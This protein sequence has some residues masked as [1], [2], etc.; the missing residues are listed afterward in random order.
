MG[1]GLPHLLRATTGLLLATHN[2]YVRWAEMLRARLV[3]QRARLPQA[4]PFLDYLHFP[5][6]L[7]HTWLPSTQNQCGTYESLMF[8]VVIPTCIPRR[9][10]SSRRH[11]TTW[12]PPLSASPSSSNRYSLTFLAT[13]SLAFSA[14]R[15]S[16]VRLSHGR[17][18]CNSLISTRPPQH[19]R[20][21]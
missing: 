20:Y 18:S 6:L 19:V 10:I 13:R 4:F 7:L 16:G 5:F 11:L 3:Q 12:R 8:W 1:T 15:G 9:S 14:S 21:G 17:P 2:H